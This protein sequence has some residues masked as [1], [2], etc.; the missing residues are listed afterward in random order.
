[1]FWESLSSAFWFQSNW[2]LLACS[3]HVVNFF[4]LIIL[5]NQ[6]ST[7]GCHS[8]NF[9]KRLNESKPTLAHNDSLEFKARFSEHTSMMAEEERKQTPGV[10]QN[11][12]GCRSLGIHTH[13]QKDTGKQEMSGSSGILEKLLIVFGKTFPPTP[14]L[15]EGKM[16]FNL[17][18][19]SIP[20]P[21]SST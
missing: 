16:A 15:R 9:K 8:E 11:T 5:C 21:E 10:C 19:R 7:N 2:V 18:P 14:G 17:L 6:K 1:M 4:H 20:L 13:T 12:Q 3:Q